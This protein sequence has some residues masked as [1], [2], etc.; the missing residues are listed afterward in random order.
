MDLEGDY[1]ASDSENDYDEKEK[2]LLE[3]VRRRRKEYSDSED[4]VFG[5]GSDSDNKSDLAASDIEDQDDDN[6]PDRRAWGK[7]KRQYYQTDYVDADY[8]GFQ[9]KDAQLAEQEE[10]EARNLQKQLA[11]QLDEDDFSLDMLNKKTPEIEKQAEEIVKTDFSK[12]S[13]RQKIQLLQKESPEFFSLVED[14]EAKMNIGKD[15]LHPTVQKFKKGQIPDCNAVEFVQTYYE[16]I[17]NYCTNIYMYLLLKASKTSNIQ[18]HPVIKRLYQYRQLLLQLEPVFEEIIKPQIELLL[19]DN[20]E[21]ADK[22]VVEK[23]KMLKL[24]SG[25]KEK[26]SKRPDNKKLKE[27]LDED[28]DKKDRLSKRNDKKV[29]F[30]LESDKVDTV[31]KSKKDKGLKNEKGK[32][33]G[34]EDR[35]STEI[36]GIHEKDNLD[37]NVNDE[38]GLSD[39]GK[40]QEEDY[41]DDKGEKRA[42]TYQMAKNKGL[43][44]HRKKE[45]R[46]PRV[47]H[48]LK[49]RKAII[50]RKGAVREVR[51]E[52][53]R[54]D[55]EIS[56]IKASVTK[57]IKIKT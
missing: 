56:G 21:N 14:F 46:N 18:N 5:V 20:E 47:K 43:T 41:T 3:K 44:P 1:S 6:L 54:Y 29:K 40:E 53:K 22:P 4:E 24:L 9:G 34:S 11:Q 37:E 31:T 52:L 17:L 38:P 55:G 49:Y 36:A 23:K 26:K 12:L 8:G 19:Q 39:D 28:S 10:E 7:D 32:A 27:H 16:L 30:N 42:I 33:V 48:K 15:Y 51:K 35:E 45:H 13:T 57:S 2:E 25:V 50:R